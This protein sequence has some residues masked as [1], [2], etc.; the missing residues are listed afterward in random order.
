MFDWLKRRPKDTDFAADENARLKRLT[1]EAGSL[2][3]AGKPDE[4]RQHYEEILRADQNDLLAIY[5][6]ATLLQQQGALDEAKRVC[7]QGLALEPDQLGLMARHAEIL[8]DS[9]DYPAA[10]T[11]YQR[12]QAIDPDFPDVDAHLADAFCFL[13]R[14]REGVEAFERALARDPDSAT[15]QSNRLFVLNYFKLL[16]RDALFEEHRKWGAMHEA[17]LRP[18]WLPFDLARD[19][20]RKLRIGYVSPDL[21]NHAVA[22]FIEGVLREHDRK[23]FEIHCFDVSPFAEDH[24]TARLRG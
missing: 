23:T 2:Q 9:G 14:G 18:H 6:L 8:K 24:V 20:D 7:E 11:D 22:F 1:D 16:D 4:A 15:L 12:I 5:H 3:E 13:G 19:P 10:L 17:R 21:R